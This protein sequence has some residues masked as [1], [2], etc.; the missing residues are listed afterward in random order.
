MLLN[1]TM[2][3]FYNQQWFPRLWEGLMAAPGVRPA[4]TPLGAR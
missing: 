4:D 1:A 3:A 2:L